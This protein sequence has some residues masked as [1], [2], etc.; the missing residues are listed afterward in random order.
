MFKFG[1]FNDTIAETCLR[2]LS[3]ACVSFF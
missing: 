2:L 1:K 3:V